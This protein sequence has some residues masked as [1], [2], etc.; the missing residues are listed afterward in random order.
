MEGDM[1]W[2]WAF[3]CIVITAWLIFSEE[4]KQR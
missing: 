2:L 4:I 3:G 1:I